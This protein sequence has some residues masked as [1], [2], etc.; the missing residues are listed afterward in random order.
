M[1]E[2]CKVCTDVFIIKIVL[3]VNSEFT[4]YTIKT[5]INFNNTVVVVWVV[6]IVVVVLVEARDMN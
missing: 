1:S 2:Y 4:I 5:F 6:V 3:I